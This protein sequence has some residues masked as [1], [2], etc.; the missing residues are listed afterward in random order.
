MRCDPPECFTYQDRVFSN[1]INDLIV[2]T[3]ANYE[4][5]MFR[6][7]VKTGFYDLQVL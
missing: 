3:D 7:A 1:E 5:T 6:D 4:N 2:K